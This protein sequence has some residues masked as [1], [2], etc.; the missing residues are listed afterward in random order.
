MGKRV[1][2]IAGGRF[3]RAELVRHEASISP[4]NWRPFLQSNVAN[5]REWRYMLAADFFEHD[6]AERKA[7]G[8]RCMRSWT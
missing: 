3:G 7:G 1:W 5:Q 6:P 2:G 4:E 8:R